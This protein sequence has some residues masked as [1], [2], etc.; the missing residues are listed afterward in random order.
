MYYD[1]HLLF[2]VIERSI[3]SGRLPTTLALLVGAF[4]LSVASVLRLLDS[5]LLAM[6][7]DFTS[8]T[9]SP[10]LSPASNPPS[11]PPR[12][13]RPPARGQILSL[14]VA[15]VKESSSGESR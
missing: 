11:T 7:W 8:T 3:G 5:D 1:K 9:S 6:S 12:E 14:V 2:V 13:N 4:F 10:K 15:L